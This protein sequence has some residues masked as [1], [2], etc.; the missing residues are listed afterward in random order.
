[1][2]EATKLLEKVKKLYDEKKYDEII[3]LLPDELMAKNE[4][5]WNAKGNAYSELNK[6]EKAITNFKKAIDINPEYADAYYNIGNTYYDLQEYNNAIKHFEKAI[7]IN[8]KDDDVYYNTGNS[9]YHLKEY[10]NAIKYFEKAIE[11]NPKKSEAYNNLGIIYY[12]LNEYEKVIENCKK[13]IEINSQNDAPFYNLGNVYYDIK[14]YENA[15]EYYQKMV[16]HS[17]NN[18]DY[19][20]QI[21]Q[22]KLKEIEKILKNE[23]LKQ[24][25]EL[26]NKIK[27]L[28]VCKDECIT[29]YTTM[30]TANALIL[31]YSP[32]RLSEGAYLNDT[33]EGNE[34]LNYIKGKED[35]N[36][37]TQIEL[38]TQKPFIGSFV[39]GNKNDDLTLWRMYGKEEKEEAKGCSI[40][41]S[42][43]GF[44]DAIRSAIK[45]TSSDYDDKTS[46][47][48][49]LEDF[50]FYRVA[51]I[52]KPN[53]TDTDFN[54]PGAKVA[55]NNK[56]KKWME[57]L[58]AKVIAFYNNEKNDTNDRQFVEAELNK[59]NYLFK[60]IAY[61]YE[62]EIRLV[63][64]RGIMPPVVDTQFIPPKVYIELVPINSFV[65][66]ITLGPKVAL[67]NEW[68]SAMNYSLKQ[69]DENNTTEIY[70]SHLPFK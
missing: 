14:E 60:S 15:K 23:E 7:E 30:S 5:L 26:I 6:F 67:A 55:E 25:T 13:S 33:S 27:D 17:K 51:Y 54:I 52:S 8:P 64:K 20:T 1:M 2:E 47:A 68:A 50:T 70:I 57:E 63:V 62:H 36:H 49:D 69:K 39:P 24:I 45:N 18:S 41:I 46:A 29:H 12:F 42:R 59:I 11:I 10:N 21:A 43:Q 35:N 53:D 4:K 9:Y 22:D 34:F 61:Q 65:K 37:L 32:I 38:F 40:T 58:K 16:K 3:A 66:K 44:T 19:Y 31:Q 28:L 56:L 48:N